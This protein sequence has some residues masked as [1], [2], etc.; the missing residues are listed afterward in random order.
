MNAYYLTCAVPKPGNARKKKKQNGWKDKPGRVCVY[1]GTGG[2]ERHEV[3]SG[4]LRQ[5]S[6]DLGFQIDVSKA[7]H[8]EL[9]ANAT[10]W[11]Q[12]EN[13]RLKRFFQ[14]KYEAECFA[15]GMGAAAAREAWMKLIG[16]NHL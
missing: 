13:L 9:H 15:A 2:A 14:E 10:E 3:F 1:D 7:R 6:I 8:E 16:K 11:A 4:P 5:V 12:R